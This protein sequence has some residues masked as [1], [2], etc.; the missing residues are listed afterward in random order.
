MVTETYKVVGEFPYYP[1]LLG[2]VTMT[3]ALRD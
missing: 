3:D 1:V 2:W